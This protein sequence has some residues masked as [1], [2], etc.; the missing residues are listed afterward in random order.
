MPLRFQLSRK[1][2]S[3]L[4]PNT[5]N[6]ARPGKWGNLIAIGAPMNVTATDGNMYSMVATRRIAIAINRELVL[7]Q[8]EK[9]PQY[10]DPLRGKNVACWCGLSEE[11]HGDDLLLLANK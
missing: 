9:N 10:L 4:P 8:L 6:V 2:G 5:I 1:K 7:T 3:R 11:C